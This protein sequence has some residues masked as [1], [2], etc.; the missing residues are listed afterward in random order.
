MSE[1]RVQRAGGIASHNCRSTATGSSDSAMPMRFDTR[2]TWR[3]T[4]RPG[5]PRAW[6]RT[7]FAVFRPTPGSST[8]ASIAAGTLP[9]WRAT[10]ASAM[11]MSDFDLARKKPVEWICGSSSAVVAFASARASR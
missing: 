9:P 5:T 7:T 4:G 11:P 2:R 6:P 8:S 3:S 10:S 1:V